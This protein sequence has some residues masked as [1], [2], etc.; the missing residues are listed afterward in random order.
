VTQETRRKRRVGRPRSSAI[1]ARLIDA[2]LELLREGGPAAVNVEAVAARSGVAK[3]TIYRRYRDRDEL[4]RG[5]IGS[6]VNPPTEP[7]VEDIRDRLTWALG[8]VHAILG[9][10]LGRGGVAALLDDREPAF[11]TMVRDL[12]TP[13]TT[14]LAGL[15]DDDIVAGRLRSDLDADAVVSVMLGSYLGELLRHGTVSTDW[16]PRCVD[17]LLHAI[18]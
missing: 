6:A 18:T 10:V 7:P 1:D 2:T 5:A 4:I 17:L 3:T 11:T 15:I 13:Y 14:A 16:V 9:E 8:Q 12:L